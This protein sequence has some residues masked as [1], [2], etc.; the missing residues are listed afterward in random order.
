MKGLIV[1]DSD[2]SNEKISKKQNKQKKSQKIQVTK[3][4]KKRL[5]T[6]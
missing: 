5:K 2:F 6:S 4:V 1:Q 3:K